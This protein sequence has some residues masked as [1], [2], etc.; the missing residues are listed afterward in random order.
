M[1]AEPSRA[2][3]PDSL[4]GG[5]IITVVVA[6]LLLVG[7]VLIVG[8]LLPGSNNVK[9]ALA[10]AWFVLAGAVFGRL[11]KD[12]PGVRVPLRAAVA[13]SAVVLAGWYANSLR[14]N[15]VQEQL[16]TATPA[17]AAAP[18]PSTT[19]PDGDEVA[20]ADAASNDAA[21]D[22]GK[23]TSKREGSGSSSAAGPATKSS[24]TRAAPRKRPPTPAAGTKP[25]TETDATA[26]KPKAA[27]TKPKAAA[28]ALMAT[29][30]FTALEHETSG[31]AEIVRAAD[32]KQQLQLRDFK[33]D[34]GPDLKVYLATDS[35]AGT[36]VDLGKLKG[37]TGN[38][39]YPLPG[40]VDLAKY[41]TVLIWC[42][43]FTVGF[44][45]AAL[46]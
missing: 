40:T 13:L 31:R 25:A 11:A 20:G 27:P 8:Q 17:A 2:N 12:R 24:G 35:S 10:V 42:R 34:A 7:V 1:A 21:A 38:Q 26:P 37:N 36:F 19:A 23:R 18:G 9:I 41:D 22:P 16:L 3:R 28:P 4:L 44:G 33:T 39:I 15:D 46:K 30:S 43:A 32:G 6:G 5:V 45:Q 29:G 14:G